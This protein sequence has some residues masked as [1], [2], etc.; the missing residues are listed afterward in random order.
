[1]SSAIS[2]TFL[3]SN[4][5]KNIVSRNFYVLCG[6]CCKEKCWSKYF[7]YVICS[8]T[9]IVQMTFPTCKLRQKKY[10]LIDLLPAKTK[11]FHDFF[12]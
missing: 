6:K 5:R 9:H 10:Y 4:R 11:I 2:F 8:R 12:K 7:C 3:V 1:M